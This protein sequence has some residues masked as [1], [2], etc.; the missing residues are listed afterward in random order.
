MQRFK[1]CKIYFET[2]CYY[3]TRD[4]S[5]NQ[6][7]FC[8]DSGIICLTFHYYL[9]LLSLGFALGVLP[10][11]QAVQVTEIET[12][13][14]FSKEK[15]PRS[16]PAGYAFKVKLKH[17]LSS[18]LNRVGDPVWASLVDPFKIDGSVIAPAGSTLI[19]VV[20][21]VYPPTWRPRVH[22]YVQIRFEMLEPKNATFRYPI[23]AVINSVDNTH[24]R[25]F[26]NTTATTLQH[27]KDGN[28]CELSTG[29]VLPLLLEKPFT[30]GG[31]FVPP[32]YNAR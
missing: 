13:P 21:V 9:A 3:N 5:K 1:A 27:A 32:R 29:T 14:P 15:A 19:G 17:P 28:H 18:R 22:G 11:V 2:T 31:G 4:D 25:V 12:H 7:T 24:G 8:N 16:L 26:G 10:F 6:V 23:N 20:E 30:K